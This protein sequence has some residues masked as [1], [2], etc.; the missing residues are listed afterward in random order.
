MLVLECGLALI[1]LTI[2]GFAP[3]FFL[4]RRLRWNPMEKLCGSIGLSLVLIYLAFGIVYC[5]TPAGA[6]MPHGVLVLISVGCSAL[7]FAIRRDVRLL[8]SS[9]RVRQALLGFSFLVLW[10]LIILCTIRNYSGAYWKGD[11]QEH[12]QRSLFFLHHFPIDT[13]IFTHYQLPARPPMMNMLAAFVMGQTG[14]RFEIFQVVF[15][16]LNLLILLPSCL[17]MTALGGARRT[18]VLPLVAVFAMNPMVMQNVTFT[19]IK[20]FAAFYIILAIWFYL[21][22]WRK[23]DSTRMTAAYVAIASGLLVHYSAGV[24]CT[25]LALHYL[26]FV[27]WRR[28]R[29]WRELAMILVA[30]GV[31]LATWFGWSATVYGR[32]TTFA[33]NT[34]V[35]ASQ[36]HQGQNVRKIRSNMWNSI[37]PYVV[38]HHA[39]WFT[40]Q[41]TRA[42]ILRDNLFGVYQTNA[43]FSMGL[44][45]G[46]IVLWYLLWHFRPSYFRKGQCSFWLAMVPF[47]FVVGIATVGE[48]DIFG[49]AH[50]TQMPL[51]IL[52][53]CLLA[54]LMFTRRAWLMLIAAGCVLDFSI[55]VALQVHLE[56]LENTPHTIV[57]SG[58]HLAPEMGPP[59]VGAGT[60]RSLSATAWTNWFR[61]HQYALSIEWLRE[62]TAYRPGDAA[63]RQQSAALQT[64]LEGWVNED[65]KYWF[66]WYARHNGTMTF[67]GDHVAGESGSGTTPSMG[68]LILLMVG[69]MAKTLKQGWRLTAVNRAIAPS[70]QSQ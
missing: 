36:Q 2:C 35:T 27:F 12:F 4:L 39:F 16:F 10:T 70:S 67:L 18:Y 28:P 30:S 14:D 26:L 25:F 62:L 55:G 65:Q 52:G 68:L 51:E 22:G 48:K 21:A 8:F 5:L 15:A 57:F 9:F 37:V 60:P 64:Q 6:E 50:L 34:S 31:L 42:G 47:C 19:W 45:G 66:G 43:I 29:R 33:S 59:G 53:L 11:W 61:K 44:I 58:L 54:D 20:V 3:G 38:R 46:P 41:P 13:P 56:S 24:Y 1:L 23:Q 69:L 7:L 49:V 40:D 32:Q 17:I 63:F